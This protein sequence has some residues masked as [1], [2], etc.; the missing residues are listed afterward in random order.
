MRPILLAFA[1]LIA[2]PAF[3]QGYSGLNGRNHPELDWQVAETEHFEIMY[4]AHLAGIEAQAAAV[5]EATYAT[6]SENFGGVVFDDKIRIYLSDEDEIANGSAYDVGSAGFTHIW[7]NANN[8]AEIWTGEVKW[9][10]KVIAHELAHIFHF[11][12]VRSSLGLLQNLLA[13]AYPAWWVEGLAQYETEKWDA[14]RGDRW[15]R[16]AIFEDRL[17]TSD[18][19]SNQNGRLLYALGN[20]Q[21]RYLAETYGDSTITQILEHRKSALLGLA[22]VHDFYTAFEDVVGE[23]YKEFQEEWRKNA[24]VYYNTLAGQ[25]ERL[26][27]LHV[28]PLRLPGQYI[29]SIDFSPD[30]TLI[31]ATVL[32]SVARPV[33]RLFV[34]NNPGA[35]STRNVRVLAEGSLQGPIS[36]SPDGSRIAYARR[37]RGNHGSLVNDLYM[38]EVETG[39]R[40]RL[41][42]SRRAFSPSFGPD[43]RT[44]AFVGTASSAVGGTANVFLLDLETRE[45]T[46]LTHFEGDVQITSARWSPRGDQIA[47]TVFDAE[48]NRSLMTIDVALGA[49]SP[50]RVGADLSIGANDSRLPVWSP[51]GEA[52][53]F[54]SLRDDAPNVFV[55]GLP[56]EAGP[57]DVVSGEE[58]E[59]DD[60]RTEDGGR[61]TED[62]E[63][64]TEDRG[65]RTEDGGRQTPVEDTLGVEKP[66]VI[67][68]RTGGAA[69]TVIYR[70]APDTPTEPLSSVLRPPSS[71]QRV[72]FLYDG[73]TVHDWLPADSLHPAGR[74]V[75]VSSETKRRERVYVVDAARRP[76]VDASEP[77]TIPPGYGDWTTHRPPNEIPFAIAPD[78]S[79]ITARHTYNSF[80]NLTHAITLPLPY[81]D[82]AN[83]DYGFFANSIW[84]E[85]LSKHQLFVLA[86][87]SVTQFI[88]KSFLLLSYVN[89]TLAPSL[90]LDLYRF[91]SPSSFYGN[92]LLVENLTGGDLSATLPLD[93]TDTPYTTMQAGA[94]IRYAYAEPFDFADNVDL[95]TAGGELPLPEDG[96][97]TD[98]QLGFAWKHQRPYRYNVIHPLDGTGVRVRVTMG[99]PILGSNNQFVR[100][101]LA[102]YWIS[103]Q[104][105]IG[106][107]YAYGR[108]TAQFG[109]LLAQDYIGLSRYDD[110]DIQLPIL[111]SITLDDAER[112]R[113]YRSYAVG[114]R[115]L[116]GT[117]EYRLPPVI[118][119]STKL[120]GIVDLGRL[121]FSLF[122]DAGMVWTGSNADAAIR[123]AGVG[124]EAKNVISIGG[125]RIL[126]SLG[127]AAPWSELDE[128]LVWDDVD[129][130][131]RVQAAVAF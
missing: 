85:P 16:T 60:Q 42:H 22:H 92:A 114:N 34:M 41:T 18:D 33:R 110:I 90:R 111:G 26:D 3:G 48:G 24:N 64:R 118:D 10:R 95:E 25:M 100:P 82:P 20:S 130:Y 71:E 123:R 28:D 38:V 35:D 47:I 12:T 121:G 43:G 84:L 106:R 37:I 89:N 101:D 103:P 128:N 87:V 4:P 2:A 53:A 23:P 15:L 81:A 74:L 68:E 78:S 61:R 27:S 58:W 116:F 62:G 55:V 44:L 67:P 93:L 49:P 107:F 75:L 9:L 112:V 97:R 30:T 131:Y 66:D 65:Q 83:N 88:D 45:E 94:R 91:P 77:L 76:T 39:R 36:W 98:L 5:A 13:T 54:T 69:E 52:M 122:A 113:G 108:A 102:A 70:R 59:M 117:L 32:T 6:L 125:F 72:T 99:A 8:T 14:Q 17:S 51:N 63:E 7:V 11:R 57:D 1:L 56:G 120:L 109:E 129:L 21:L 46:S 19:N 80:A 119:L 115:V 79:L 29:Y 50:V 73:A 31:A 86:G 124:I 126:H 105:G 40:T 127:V 96:Y 104:L